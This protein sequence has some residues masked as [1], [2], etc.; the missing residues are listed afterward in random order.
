MMAIS[1]ADG[2]AED[3]RRVDQGR[4]KSWFSR[5]VQDCIEVVAGQ[6][7]DVQWDACFLTD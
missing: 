5:I 4:L 1:R 6:D 7:A 2:D 3:E